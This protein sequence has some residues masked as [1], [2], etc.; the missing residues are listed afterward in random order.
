MPHPSFLS[1]AL[2]SLGILCCLCL[3]IGG[4]AAVSTE[5]HVVKL[6][7]DGKT[8]IAER[9]VD[10]RWLES[11]LQV[12]GDGSTHYYHQGPTFDDADLWDPTESK[13]V[14]DKDM[15]AVKGTAV[16]DLCSLVGGMQSGDTL[17]VRS[18]DGFSKKFSYRTVYSPSARQGPMVLTWFRADEGYV[19]SYSTGMRIVF[20]AD[21]STNP[22]G[23]HVFGNTD[24]KESMPQNEWHFFNGVYPTT[25]GLSVQSVSEIRILSSL[26]AS[27]TAPPTTQPTITPSPTPKVTPTTT[28][29]QTG[30]VTRPPS[31]SVSPT[32]SG[33]VQTPTSVTTSVV[34]GT[35]APITT[36]TSGVIV[37][38][39]T[40]PTAVSPVPS[41]G[42]SDSEPTRS[43]SA[44][45]PTPAGTSSTVAP[46]PGGTVVSPAPTGP[47]VTIPN[48]T[49]GVTGTI[50][51][52]PTLTPV[53]SPPTYSSSTDWSYSG[54]V[55]YMT[56]AS[57][58]ATTT[59][60]TSTPTPEPTPTPTD[61][62]VATASANPVVSPVTAGVLV[63]APSVVEAPVDRSYNRTVTRSLGFTFSFTVRESG[64]GTAVTESRR[65]GSGVI[66]PY[67]PLG[68]F[69][70]AVKALGAMID[71][72]FT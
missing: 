16:R 41:S 52:E 2:W 8:V 60:T 35:T 70:A 6:A 71:P 31:V 50:S 18:G 26:P 10:Y 11:N 30:T 72:F 44:T 66:S 27:T 40:A 49:P 55:D 5:I 17:V 54:S 23:L 61:T 68:A 57:G 46:S 65:A 34:P 45:T 7:A 64:D 59:A 19:P 38:T 13:N 51:L 43:P 67:S 12:R 63:P 42:G 36:V 24:M 56:S 22:F 4:A 25:T 29:V 69:W 28:P 1:R 3:L 53:T 62:P 39:A 58:G 9:T 48:L 47:V 32:P 33:S 21:T 20:Y 14:Q 15:G 37:T